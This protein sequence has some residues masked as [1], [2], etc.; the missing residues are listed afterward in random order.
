M[1]GTRWIKSGILFS[2][3]WGCFSLMVFFSDSWLARSNHWGYVQQCDSR[4]LLWEITSFTTPVTWH[5]VSHNKT[6]HSRYVVHNHK[7]LTEES[8]I[9]G[10]NQGLLYNQNLKSAKN[11]KPLK[12]LRDELHGSAGKFQLRFSGSSLLAT[13][14]CRGALLPGAEQALALQKHQ[15]AKN[16]QGWS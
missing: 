1:V 10:V 4:A 8:W 6:L 16:L 3:K 7:K 14:A 9:L 13:T 2:I 15:Q 5:V 11:L 12:Q